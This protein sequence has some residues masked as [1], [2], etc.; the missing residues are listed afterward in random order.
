MTTSKTFISKCY[1]SQFGAAAKAKIDCEISLEKMGFKNTGLPRTTAT[2]PVANFFLTL[3]SVIVGL[4]RL[5]KGST[6]CIQYPTKKYYKLMVKVAKLKKCQ[7]ITVIHDLRS[8]RKQK[9]DIEEEIKT[10]NLN[11]IVISH[12]SSMSEWLKSH[13]LTATLVD[14]DLFDYLC[15]DRRDQPSLETLP[16]KYSL[17]FAGVLE[18]RK[19]GFLYGLDEIKAKHFR[20]NL[21]GIGFNAKELKDG[22]II[23]YKGFF[24]ADD[25]VNQLDGHFGIVWDGISIDECA[26][27]F[28]EYLKINNPH[29]TSMY[30][31]AGLPIIIWDQAAMAKV[32]LSHNAGVAVSSLAEIDD[33][34][35]NLKFEDYKVMKQNAENL[36]RQLGEGHFL[37][38]A[39][40][41][42][43]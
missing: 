23:D 22:S 16:D 29:K 13:K 37:M 10:L 30:L 19:N 27:S 14:L 25:I 7:V 2:N 34:L 36:S 12:N 33:V 28:G 32:I 11:D 8:H 35:Q 15:H 39:I 41:K 5:P 24:P 26:G 9:M 6:L 20:L 18:K 21:Y 43:L 31:R 3:T 4:L 42:S 1:R 38:S 40:E 17:V